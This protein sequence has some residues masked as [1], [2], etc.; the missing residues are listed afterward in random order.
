MPSGPYRNKQLV[1]VPAHHLL[2]LY[3]KKTNVEPELLEYI[4]DNLDV[5]KLEL[6]KSKKTKIK[7]NI[8]V[9]KIDDEFDD[10]E[11]EFLDCD[12]EFLDYNED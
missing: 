10:E 2:E 1:D 9:V 12:E 11:A 7:K 6:K 3:K 4:E 5:L 8:V